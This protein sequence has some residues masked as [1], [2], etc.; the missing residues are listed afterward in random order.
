MTDAPKNTKR[1]NRSLIQIASVST[2][3]VVLLLIGVIVVRGLVGDSGPRT[4]SGAA[5]R[6]L[7]PSAR[8][9]DRDGECPDLS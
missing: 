4:A 5:A 9:P 2:L 1:V 7:S 8:R 6:P 3:G